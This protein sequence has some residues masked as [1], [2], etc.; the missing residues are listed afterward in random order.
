MELSPQ[1]AMDL[2]SP[3]GMDG[4]D[5]SEQG[6][7]NN[8]NNGNGTSET[9]HSI[10]HSRLLKHKPNYLSIIRV[11]AVS[12][13]AG[14]NLYNMAPPFALIRD[15]L[16]S[17]LSDRHSQMETS[18]GSATNTPNIPFVTIVGQQMDL[19]MPN[20]GQSTQARYALSRLF[21]FET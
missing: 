14:G 4:P 5:G 9:Y 6:Q 2:S 7:S 10:A 21:I 16:Q 17:V 12:I 1:S 18:N 15:A 13:G 8:N 19:G 11:C 20:S 3:S